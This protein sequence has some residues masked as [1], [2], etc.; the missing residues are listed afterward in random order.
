M[1]RKATKPAVRAENKKLFSLLFEMTRL[2]KREISRECTFIPSFLHA[3]TLRFIQTSEQ[4]G[5]APTMKDVADYLK[6]APPSATSLV[7]SFV[8]DH[9]IM[10]VADPKD[11]RIVRLS[12]SKKGEK[13]LDKTRIQREQAVANLLAPLS[14]ADMDEFAR[15][16]TVIT[17]RQ[18][19]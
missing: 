18:D 17:T 8:K 4:E 14:K 6:I 7:N 11:R 19:S 16:L 3:E 15:I 10:R 12:L 2:M 13:L 5:M 1:K 9:V